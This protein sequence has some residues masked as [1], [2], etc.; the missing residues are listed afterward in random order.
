MPVKKVIKGGRVGY[1][2]GN[3]GKIYTGPKAR[4]K[5]ALQGA[6]VQKSQ[7]KKGKTKKY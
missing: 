1:Q 5:A 6:A 4:Q 2:W 7:T 3:T